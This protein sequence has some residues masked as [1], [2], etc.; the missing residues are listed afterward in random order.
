MG[1]VY[2]LEPIHQLMVDEDRERSLHDISST[3]GR[4]TGFEFDTHGFPE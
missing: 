2:I 4:E 3:G 1:I